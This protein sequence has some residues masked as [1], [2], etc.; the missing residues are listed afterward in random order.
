MAN[1]QKCAGSMIR[2]QYRQ[3]LFVRHE[4]HASLHDA[5]RRSHELIDAQGTSEH[6]IVDEMGAPLVAGAELNRLR[7]LRSRRS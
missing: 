6:A 4:N 5:I 7:E 1:R 2:L 3:G